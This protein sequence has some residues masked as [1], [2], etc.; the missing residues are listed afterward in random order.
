MGKRVQP[1]NFDYNGNKKWLLRI[2]VLSD[3]ELVICYRR[4]EK[5]YS[6]IFPD[7]K[8]FVVKLTFIIPTGL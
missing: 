1:L 3:T 8:N 4:Q 7:S 6:F 2:V 5:L